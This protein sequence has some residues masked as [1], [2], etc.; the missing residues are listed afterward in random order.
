MSDLPFTVAALYQFTAF[1]DLEA[2]QKPLQECCDA[3]GVM[4]T[5]L[6]APEGLNGTIAGSQAGID[7]ALEYIRAIPGCQHVEVKF[8]YAKEQPFLRMKVRLKK[9]IVTL[10][11]PQV[12]PVNEVGQYVAPEDWNDLISEP[13]VVVIDTR[14]DYEVAIGTFEGAIDPETTAFRDFPAWFREQRG[15]LLG[16]SNKPKV[17]MF[18]TGGIRCEKSTAFLKSEGIEDVYHLKGGI[19][20]YLEEIPPE[21]SK[22]E[23]DCFVFDERV[24]VGHGLKQGDYTLCRA[25]RY[26]LTKEE[27]ASEKFEDGVS[28]PHCF[29]KKSPQQRA[30]Y[31][32]RE[33]QARLA[34]ERGEKHVGVSQEELRAE[35]KAEKLAAKEAAREAAAGEN[36]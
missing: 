34:R 28:C 16:E 2:V 26:P 30:R 15:K 35:R 10:G 6:V 1:G 21:E 8:S 29:D 27:H 18:C 7:A 24:S 17:A 25:C 9:E 32:E 4:G 14:N 33:K 13:G 3:N 12:D 5:L 23:G 31:A 20:K 19:L 22:W 36:G 11:Q